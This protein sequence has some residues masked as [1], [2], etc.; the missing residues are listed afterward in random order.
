MEAYCVL[1]G[2]MEAKVGDDITM[3]RMMDSL[4]SIKIKRMNNLDKDE[5][6]RGHS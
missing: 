2:K 4:C 1:R 3:P 6:S 5:V